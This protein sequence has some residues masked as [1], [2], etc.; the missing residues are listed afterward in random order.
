MA[1]NFFYTKEGV[2]A[3]KCTSNASWAV[4]LPTKSLPNLVDSYPFR[5]YGGVL[6]DPFDP[7]DHISVQTAYR[8][9]RRHLSFSTIPFVQDSNSYLVT[10][11]C[12]SI[13]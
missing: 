6:F 7:R 4:P 13:I 12:A 9:F 2:N 8:K 10:D 1:I 11:T 5:N 3:S